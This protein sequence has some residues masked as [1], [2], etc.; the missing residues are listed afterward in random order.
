MASKPDTCECSAT[1]H[2]INGVKARGLDMLVCG[3]E[4]EPK[5]V[6]CRPCTKGN[7]A[8]VV[9]PEYVP[10]PVAAHLDRRC[11]R[12]GFDSAKHATPVE[13][14]G[15]PVQRGPW[16]QRP[17]GAWAFDVT[18][19]A[20]TAEPVPTTRPRYGTQ[21]DRLWRW[22]ARMVPLRPVVL[23]PLPPPRDER[24]VLDDVADIE[25]AT[26]RQVEGVEAVAMS[27]TLVEGRKP[28]QRC[29]RPTIDLPSFPSRAR[30]LEFTRCPRC[31]RSTM[32][33]VEEA[34]VA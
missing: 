27:A 1:D 4:I 31:H 10:Q 18:A 26:G 15:N 25:L 11:D 22:V 34:Q 24:E 12:C 20:V 30:G 19:A 29:G 9:C 16:S 7:H 8:R 21:P 14:G 2:A 6:R 33:H 13:L 32:H 17:D 23:P 5:H 3:A 28:C